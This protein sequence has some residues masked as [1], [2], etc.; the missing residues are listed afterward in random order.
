[1]ID[2]KTD[3]Q[4][5]YAI[6]KRQL[7]AYKDIIYSAANSRGRVQVVLSGNRPIEV[8]KNESTPM[9]SIDGRPEDLQSEYPVTFMP[10]I[11]QNYYKIIRWNGQDSISQEDKQT[12]EK[13]AEAVHDQGKK[14]RLWA[15]PETEHVWQVLL[16]AGVDF[17]NTDKLKELQSY[18]QSRKK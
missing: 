11:S 15:S 16:D 12:L 7:V 4:A 2:I 17:I 14:L 3:A 1:M 18:M 13:L 9:V 8:V 10:L 5:T 6:L